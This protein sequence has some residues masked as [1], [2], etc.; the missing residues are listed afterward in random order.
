MSKLLALTEQRQSNEG[1]ARYAALPESTS[2]WYRRE[3]EAM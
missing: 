1:R 2:K 3:L